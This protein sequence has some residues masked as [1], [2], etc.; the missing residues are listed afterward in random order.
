M[1]P[2]ALGCYITKHGHP[3]RK[4]GY[5]KWETRATSYA[6]RQDGKLLLFSADFIEIRDVN[7]GR[8][9]QVIEGAD[10]RLLHSGPRSGT[11]SVILAAM[12][13]GDNER[14]STDKIVELAET[15]EFMSSSAA[16]PP[17]PAVWDEWDM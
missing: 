17:E 14:S 4:S 15:T 9:L 8:L 10:I 16:P 3:T 1:L 5:L 2:L 11:D 7:T 12:R 6:H 13:S